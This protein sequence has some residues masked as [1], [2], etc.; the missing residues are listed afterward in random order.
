MDIEQLKLILE[1]FKGVQADTITL[2]IIWIIYGAL[3]FAGIMFFIGWII[4]KVVALI[5][6]AMM[7]GAFMQNL[8]KEIG[9]SGWLLPSEQNRILELVKK[10][11][12]A[13]HQ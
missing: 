12:S 11:K 1:T 6:D 3:K 13:S 10:G 9:A 2:I 4:V 7:Q 8:M 5:R